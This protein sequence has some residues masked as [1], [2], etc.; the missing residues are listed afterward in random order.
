MN[1]HNNNGR[2]MTI[3]PDM[4]ADWLKRNQHNRPLRKHL[5]QRIQEEIESNHWRVNGQTISFDEQGNILD[6]ILCGLRC[7]A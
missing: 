1:T 2:L 3:T 7:A 5:V 6:G 4:A